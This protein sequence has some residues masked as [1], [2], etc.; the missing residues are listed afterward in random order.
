MQQ[1]PTPALSALSSVDLC[2][3]ELSVS[4]TKR[5]LFYRQDARIG[6]L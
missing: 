3:T 1:R 5:R 4:G 6:L 2:S